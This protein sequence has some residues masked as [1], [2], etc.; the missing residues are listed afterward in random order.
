MR[1]N[2]ILW[3]LYEDWFSIDLRS[4]IR[5]RLNRIRHDSASKSHRFFGYHGDLGSDPG[6]RYGWCDRRSPPAQMV[7]HET[8]GTPHESAFAIVP[9]KPIDGRLILGAALFGIGWG[10]AG[11]CPGQS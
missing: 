4:D 5:D 7:D 2:I 8:L 1:C 9:T 11:Y 10:L 6:L 3:G